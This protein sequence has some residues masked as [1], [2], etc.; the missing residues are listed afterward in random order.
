MKR[1]KFY[2]TEQAG[3]LKF[4]LVVWKVISLFQFTE[5]AIQYTSSASNPLTVIL[6]L[7]SQPLPAVPT[8]A[9]KIN[10]NLIL[11]VLED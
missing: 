8:M 6:D 1:K 2:V 7:T 9:N 3:K 5:I 4:Y 10:S 11:Y